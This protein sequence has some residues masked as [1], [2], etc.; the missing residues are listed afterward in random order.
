[1]SDRLEVALAEL[2]A[3]IR[4]EVAAAAQPQGPELLSVD[5]AA[6]AAG[7]GRTAMYGLIGSGR[8]RS[9]SVGRRR[10]VPRSAI[11]ELAKAGAG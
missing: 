10:L 11:A 5:E 1:M 2:A 3:A 7:L 8:V 9:V 4:A 6:T